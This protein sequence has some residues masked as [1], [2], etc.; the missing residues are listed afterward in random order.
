MPD[1]DVNI[2]LLNNLIQ[3]GILPNNVK[4]ENEEDATLYKE[5]KER[6]TVIKGK[7]SFLFF[8]LLF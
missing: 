3:Y 1:S 6:V 5:F 7:N 8:C 2:R 4:E